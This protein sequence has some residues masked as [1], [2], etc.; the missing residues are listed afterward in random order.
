MEDRYSV[1]LR[2]DKDALGL[3]L[4]TLR[5]LDRG[6]PFVVLRDEHFG[7]GRFSGKCEGCVELTSVVVIALS[8]IIVEDPKVGLVDP[9]KPVKLVCRENGLVYLD[10]LDLSQVDLGNKVVVCSSGIQSGKLRDRL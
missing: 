8:K 4:V 10:P 7:R 2:V 5:L 6:A 9:S 1:G 3:Q